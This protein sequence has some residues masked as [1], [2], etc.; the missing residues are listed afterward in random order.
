MV[1]KKSSN[2]LAENRKARHDYFIEETMEAG[3]ALVGT[4]VKSIRNGRSNLKECY[5]DFRSGELFIVNMHISPY[6]QGNI[7]NVEPLRERKLLLHKEQISRLS[8]LVARDGYTLI[9][10]ALYL[11]NG[12][13]KVAIGICR[14]KKNYD[15]RD[16]MLEKDHNREM[17][18]ELKERNK[19]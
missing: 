5:A 3:L 10:L 16:S 11:K 7:F 1:R 18:R 4:E 12:R 17:Q 2:S 6:E 15:K 14:G 13:V 19:Y 9:P 8:G